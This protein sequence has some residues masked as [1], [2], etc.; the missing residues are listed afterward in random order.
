MNF[1][2][3]SGRFFYFCAHDSLERGIVPF[4]DKCPNVLSSNE[5][6]SSCLN[7]FCPIKIAPLESVKIM[8]KRESFQHD[9][10]CARLFVMVDTCLFTAFIE[11]RNLAV[12]VRSWYTAV[13]VFFFKICFH[14]IRDVVRLL[15]NVPHLLGFFVLA[16]VRVRT[17][18]FRTA[19][20]ILRGSWPW[21]IIF[22]Y[23]AKG[24]RN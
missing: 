17:E 8:L 4:S 7:D 20:S 9:G 16:F 2:A 23:L 10:I 19:R 13:T 12:R 15:G 24:I 1:Q 11:Q 3:F 5:P 22:Y 21:N 18:F 14:Q 6:F